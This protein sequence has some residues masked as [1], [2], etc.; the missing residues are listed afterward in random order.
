VFLSANPAQS[1]TEQLNAIFP[2]IVPRL[3]VGGSIVSQAK[4]SQKQ[5]YA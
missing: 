5:R 3:I 2:S 4:A 1:P